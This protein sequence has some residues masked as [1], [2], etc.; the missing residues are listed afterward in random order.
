MSNKKHSG[1]AGWTFQ[2]DKNTKNNQ[3]YYG[4]ILRLYKSFFTTLIFRQ[5]AFIS[6]LK[7]HISV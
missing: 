7:I 3:I 5:L 2:V 1:A 6:N 4:Y